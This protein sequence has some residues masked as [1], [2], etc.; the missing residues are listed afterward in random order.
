MVAK[1]TFWAQDPAY[2][3]WQIHHEVAPITRASEKLGW[4]SWQQSFSRFVLRVQCDRSHNTISYE[5]GNLKSKCSILS[6]RPGVSS[7]TF[8]VYSSHQ[9][10]SFHTIYYYLLFFGS[11]GLTYIL[12]TWGRGPLPVHLCTI[13][14]NRVLLYLLLNYFVPEVWTLSFCTWK[15]ER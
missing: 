7:A 11:V 13:I 2:G 9:R 15:I 8:P 12:S 14:W 6:S 1:S 10:A 3:L 5:T 4:L